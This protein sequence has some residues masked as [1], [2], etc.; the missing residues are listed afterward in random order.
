V[1]VHLGYE[2]GSG[3]PIEI[4]LGHLVVSGQTQLSGKTT[5]LE[6]IVQRSGL[7]A[8][9]FITKRGEG[10]FSGG[11]E[12]PPYYRSPE[13]AAMWQY[14]SEVLQAKFGEK[15]K[16]ERGWIMRVSRGAP[17]LFAVHTNIRTA[18]QTAKRELDRSMYE[19][20]DEYF[21]LVLPE[22]MKVAV[23]SPKLDLGNGLNVMNLEHFSTDVQMLCIAAVLERVYRKEQGVITIIPEAWEMVPQ[24]RNTPVKAAAATMFRKGA[25]LKNFVW[26]D[27][28]D[29]A[30]VDKQALKQVS[31][32]ILGVQREEN[33]ARRMIEHLD[34][35]GPKPKLADVRTLRIGEFFVSFGRELRKVYVQP[36]W[37]SQSNA[38]QIAMGDLSVSD[39]AAPK[40]ERVAQPP[41]AVEE[42]E[43]W[44]EKF[45]QAERERV[46]LQKEVDQLNRKVE[47]LI[48]VNANAPSSVAPTGPGSIQVERTE[49]AVSGAAR[50]SSPNNGRREY[51]VTETFDNEQLYQAFKARLL[52]EE[53]AALLSIVRNRPEIEISVKREKIEMDTST[54]I[55]RVALL[56]ADGFFDVNRINAEVMNELARR[57]FPTLAPNIKTAFQKLNEMGFLI[58]ADKGRYRA[59]PEMKKNV[60]NV[61][62]A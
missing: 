48:R 52:E 61:E 54:A 33:E 46:R 11:R 55:G 15:M 35:G 18:L 49:H 56:I 9:A 31:V 60:V 29:L 19:Q 16:F 7:R 45:E 57:G 25:A 12:I 53:P 41:S 38:L 26:F 28:Q 62:A 10:S 14:V 24:G 34:V 8:I 2:I 21:N 58:S 13:S 39:F 43:V 20:L 44:K 4:P 22:L 51:S 36:A 27:S 23:R 30:G 17:D 47:Q 3:H 50:P 32:W 5:T 1:K 37:M 42:D 59:V 40:H 6:A